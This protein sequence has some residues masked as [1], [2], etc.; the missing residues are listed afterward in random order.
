[1]SLGGNFVRAVPER[2]AVEKAWQEQALTVYIAT[3]LNRSHLIHGKASY[4]LPCLARS[5][6][7]VQNGVPQSVSIEDSFSHIHG[8]MG[9]AEP[10]S[11][12]LMSETA[13][14]A[15]MAAA[16]TDPSPKRSWTAWAGDYAKVRDLIEQTYPD[17]FRDYS[18]RMFEKGGFYRGNPAHE[19]EWKTESGKAEFT[20]PTVHSA[21]GIGDAPGR[22]HLIT[23]RSNDQFNTTIYGFDDR[24]R[25]LHGSRMVLLISPGDI[26]RQGL[27]EGQVVTLSADAGDGVVREIGGLTV[28]PFDLPAGCVGGYYPEMNPLIP[29]WYHDEASKTPASKGVPVR[30]K[31]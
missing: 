23:M 6:E 15:R 28:T 17:Q 11:P 25:G 14:V 27:R 2:E 8:S 18:A 29:L 22:L 19:R 4:L 1:V 16:A 12:N 5:E 9:H 26:Q 13:I 30:I 7:D 10:A 21:L 31:P 24:L 3:K 20:V